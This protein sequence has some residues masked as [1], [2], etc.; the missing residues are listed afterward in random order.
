M[1]RFGFNHF[2]KIVPKGRVPIGQLGFVEDDN[3]WIFGIR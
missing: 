1:Y 3:L 2:Q